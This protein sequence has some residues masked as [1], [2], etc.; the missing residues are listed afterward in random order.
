MT[1]VRKNHLINYCTSAPVTTPVVANFLF[2]HLIPQSNPYLINLPLQIIPF[3]FQPIIII[4]IMPSTS[5]PSTL[6]PSTPTFCTSAS[7]ISPLPPIPPL[8]TRKKSAILSSLARPSDTYTDLS[9]K[10]SIDV[11]IRPLIDRLNALE[12]VVTTSS[13]AGRVSVFLE[14]R[15]GGGEEEGKVRGEEVG[16][17]RGE[18]GKDRSR[19]KGRGGRWLFVSHD[20]LP[21]H[22][23]LSEGGWMRVLGLDKGKEEGGGGEMRRENGDDGGGEE[24]GGCGSNLDVR[25]TRFIRFQ[26]EPMVSHTIEGALQTTPKPA[27]HIQLTHKFPSPPPKLDPP[28]NSF[29]PPPRR[30]PPNR[31]PK[32]RLPRIRATKPQNPPFRPPIFVPHRCGPECGVRDWGCDW[33]CEKRGRRRRRRRRR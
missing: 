21:E 23:P 12:G 15:K 6:S 5:N 8:F 2:L 3:A 31:R 33:V 26:F 29:L 22:V 14:G 10:G 16:R 20:P 13:C 30:T 25:R 7:S 32:L 27:T 18:E 24:E 11:R 17:D 1:R 28:H 19:G 9:P 4:I